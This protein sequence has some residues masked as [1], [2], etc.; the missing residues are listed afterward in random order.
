[1]LA[2][3]RVLS[4]NQRSWGC[5][6][7][8]PVPCLPFFCPL[9]CG[10]A[11]ICSSPLTVPP[12]S[13]HD[14][15]AK[16]QG[17]A[18]LNQLDVIKELTGSSMTVAREWIILFVQHGTCSHLREILVAS[19]MRS[20]EPTA[21]ALD[22]RERGKRRVPPSEVKRSGARKNKVNYPKQK[23]I[24]LWA[25]VSSWIKCSSTHLLYLFHKTISSNKYDNTC[26]SA[27]Q[28][29]NFCQ[30]ARCASHTEC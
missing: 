9:Q 30:G 11:F 4:E 22:N 25:L 24:V 29:K 13:S 8:E 10:P 15:N 21:A 27:L 17:R 12:S 23:Y 5:C 16:G 1:M 28:I 2:Q 14:S 20:C 18:D 26:K 7:N 6:V 3:D 19:R